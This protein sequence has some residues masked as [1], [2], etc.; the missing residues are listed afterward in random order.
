MAA[1]V[2]L[3]WRGSEHWSRQLHRCRLCPGV[4]QTRDDLGRPCHKACA[5]AEVTR[6]AARQERKSTEWGEEQRWTA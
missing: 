2:V 4:T 1:R 3:D 5:E 6:E